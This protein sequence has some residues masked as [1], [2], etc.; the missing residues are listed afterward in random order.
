MPRGM[1]SPLSARGAI[2]RPTTSRAR[3]GAWTD[4]VLTHP[5]LNGGVPGVYINGCSGFTEAGDELAATHLPPAVVTRVLDWA[6][7]AEAAGTGL[8]AYVGDEPLES[9][10]QL[11]YRRERG[12][13]PPNKGDPRRAKESQGDPRRAEESPGKWAQEEPRGAGLGLRIKD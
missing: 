5:V 10:R 11:R 6:A 3:A 7:G 12:H 2:R 9:G 1:L 4:A 13:R 8:V